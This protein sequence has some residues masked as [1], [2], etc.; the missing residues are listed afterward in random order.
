MNDDLLDALVFLKH[1][2]KKNPRKRPSKSQEL[3]TPSKPK[4]NSG[5]V[6]TSKF[7]TTPSTPRLQNKQTPV[8]RCTPTPGTSRSQ[9]RM[10][11]TAGTTTPDTPK[12]TKSLFRFRQNPRGQL[13]S[14]CPFGTKV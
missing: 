8:I 11:R 1:N 6:I 9:V 3:K 4:P 12:T 13:I 14:R 5:S 7:Q 10:S 2:D